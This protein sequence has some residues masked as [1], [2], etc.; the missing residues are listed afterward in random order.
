MTKLLQITTKCPKLQI[1]TA[2]LLHVTTK[3]VQIATGITFQDK[4]ITN[5]NYDSY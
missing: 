2:F 3:F 4:I 1:T 5:L